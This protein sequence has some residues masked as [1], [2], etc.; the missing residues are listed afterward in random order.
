MSS[1]KWSTENCIRW[2]AW[3]KLIH[4]NVFMKPKYGTMY[5]FKSITE[6]N[7]LQCLH[8]K[9]VWSTEQHV[10]T[11]QCLHENEVQKIVSMKSRQLIHDNVFLKTKYKTLYHMKSITEIN[12]LQCLHK[13]EV[14]KIV[15]HEKHDRN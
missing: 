4:Y 5:H 2:K 1:W 15:S 9:Q 12:T 10:N 7:T 14:Q 8:E 6:I 13:N 3:Q 11:L